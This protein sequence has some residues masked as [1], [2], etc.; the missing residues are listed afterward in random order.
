MSV[1]LV[2]LPEERLPA[3]QLAQLQ[4]AAPGMRVV[5][6]TERAQNE[7]QLDQV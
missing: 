5:R 4:D 2:C 1:L 3:A 6:T 7:G